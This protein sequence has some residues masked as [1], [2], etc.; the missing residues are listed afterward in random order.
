MLRGGGDDRLHV[1]QEAEVE[2]LVGLVDD[3]DA[4]LVELEVPLAQVVEDPAGR[5]H[6]DLGA[7]VEGDD[8]RAQGRPPTIA[9]ARTPASRPAVSMS[10]A[11]WRHSS[12][13]GT[14]TRACTSGSS[15]S[16]SWT[17]GMPKASVLPVPVRAWPMRSTPASASGRHR[18]WM[19]KGC[20]IPTRA[21]EVNVVGMAPRSAKLCSVGGG[22]TVPDVG[23]KQPPGWVSCGRSTIHGS[24]SAIRLQR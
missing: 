17:I 6:D 22:A 4:K 9:T 24:G 20:S 15:G 18:V 2:H 23:L 7:L 10:P 16:T 11:T 8:L 13:V 12:R 1:G 21:N 14:R 3:Q 19:G 5:A